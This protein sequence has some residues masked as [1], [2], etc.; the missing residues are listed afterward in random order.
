MH[1]RFPALLITTAVVAVSGSTVGSANAAAPTGTQ[2]S[3]AALPSLREVIARAAPAVVAIGS[4]ATMLGSGFKLQDTPYVISAAHVVKA[5]K[6]KPQITWK[7][8]QWA[9]TIV[10]VDEATDVAVIEVP[11]DFPGPGLPLA[12][13]D[14]LLAAGDWI[15]VLG[16][17]FG[18]LPT[19][20]TG[21]V[22]SLP[23]AILAPANLSTKIQLNA[24]VNPGNSGGPVINL[25][26]AVVGVANA[27]IP[28]GF[29]LGF[30]VPVEAVRGVLAQLP[31]GKR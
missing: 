12:S 17:P 31:T 20:T 13:P 9:A 25:E 26:G 21:I 30:A 23:G 28:G 1:P 10:A 4:D 14:A 24:A 18:A 8:R 5:V 6:G 27:S 15:V 29:G 7:G 19:A 22:S 2:A 16:C 3:A 11:A